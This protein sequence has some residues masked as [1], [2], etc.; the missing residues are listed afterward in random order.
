[1]KGRDIIYKGHWSSISFKV[2]IKI[3][4]HVH[5]K[6]ICFSFIILMAGVKLGSRLPHQTRFWKLFFNFFHVCL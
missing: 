2:R 6:I 5:G 3:D 4:C 1:M